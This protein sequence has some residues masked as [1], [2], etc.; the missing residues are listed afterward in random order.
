MSTSITKLEKRLTRKV[1]LE[2]YRTFFTTYL[3]VAVIFKRLVSRDDKTNCLPQHKMFSAVLFPRE[4]AFCFDIS[5]RKRMVTQ[6][7][8]QLCKTSIS[9]RKALLCQLT[10][11]SICSITEALILLVVVRFS[12]LIKNDRNTSCSRGTMFLS[13]IKL[14]RVFC[15]N[16]WQL[17]YQSAS[18]NYATASFGVNCSLTFISKAIFTMHI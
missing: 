12:T 9:T 16:L 7:Q 4:F 8:A 2:H 14:A 17:D 6:Q 3:A 18:H 1:L 15:L 13:A 11:C 5:S 10:N